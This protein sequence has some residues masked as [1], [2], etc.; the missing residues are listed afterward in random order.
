ML[1]SEGRTGVRQD[2]EPPFEELL[3][4]VREAMLDAT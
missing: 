2:H 4:R 1:V 3:E